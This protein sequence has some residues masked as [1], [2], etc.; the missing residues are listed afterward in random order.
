M[1]RPYRDA[2]IAS[3]QRIGA[4]PLDLATVIS[5]ETGGTFSPSIRGGAG[6]R[7]IGLI[8]FGIPEQQ[9]YGASQGQSFEEQLPAVEGYLTDR[10]FKPGMGLLDLYSTINAG[11]PGR[12][13]ASD[14]GNGGAPGTVADKVSGQMGAHRQKAAAFLGGDF[15]PS[16]PAGTNDAPT[17]APF[18]FRAPASGGDAVASQA[19]APATDDT[20]DIAAILRTLMPKA[21][22]QLAPQPTEAPAAAV[23][24]A[25]EPQV[26]PPWYDASRIFALLP[27][28]ARRRA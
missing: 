12:Y 11:R 19:P 22:G 8:Q 25:I 28:T 16:M 14:A 18:G 4:D 6:N 9:R 2:L 1:A 10:G 17:A 15:T 5:Y 20:A 7:H 21:P 13:D 3:A 27:T 23:A 26:A 24:P